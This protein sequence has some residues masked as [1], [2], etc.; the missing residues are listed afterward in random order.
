MDD[1]FSFFYVF[2]WHVLFN[3]NNQGVT[4]KED[5]WRKEIKGKYQE[6]DSVVE[7]EIPNAPGNKTI[8]IIVQRAGLVTGDWYDGLRLLDRLWTGMQEDDMEHT[9]KGSLF[10]YFAIRSVALY[11]RLLHKNMGGLKG[12]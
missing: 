12:I 1:A 7:K 6:R 3:E 2:I 5:R 9:R 10:R 8:A 4:K 11:A